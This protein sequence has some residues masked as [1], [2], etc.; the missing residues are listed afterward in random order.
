[1]TDI[2]PDANSELTMQ[3][4]CDEH[5]VAERD[6]QS[7][8]APYSHPTTTFQ[9]S[10]NGTPITVNTLVLQSC[11]ATICIGLLLAGIYAWKRLRKSRAK[12]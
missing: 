11:I 7:S 10:R 5:L 1:M 9:L 3:Q 8:C 2:T 4:A 12:V 6:Y